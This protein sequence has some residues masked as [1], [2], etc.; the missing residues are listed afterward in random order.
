MQPKKK[1]T[2]ESS[3]TIALK[4]PT[5]TQEVNLKEK[6]RDVFQSSNIGGSRLSKEDEK[7]VM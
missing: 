5:K 2:Q 6:A 4:I 1:V 7:K 3:E